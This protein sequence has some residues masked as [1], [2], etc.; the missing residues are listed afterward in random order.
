MNNIRHICDI[1]Q[2][3]RLPPNIDVNELF[4]KAT[5]TR[6]IF[7]H[8]ILILS[9]N[10]V[11][12]NTKLLATTVMN[13]KTIVRLPLPM[14]AVQYVPRAQGQP[15]DASTLMSGPKGQKASHCFWVKI[16]KRWM[17]FR[18]KP[19]PLAPPH[20]AIFWNVYQRVA[21]RMSESKVR[22]YNKSLTNVWIYRSE[23]NQF[24]QI[25][26]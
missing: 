26:Q 19:R 22:H 13:S 12:I 9:C 5:Q 17:S 15:L 11:F 20:I 3:C 1:L 2:L 24:L 21:L 10:E 8:Q 23:F 25:C 4:T 18:Y 6:L 16:I 14:P 7:L